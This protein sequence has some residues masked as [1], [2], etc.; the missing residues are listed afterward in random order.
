MARKGKQVKHTYRIKHLDKWKLLMADA[1]P[2]PEP[3][4]N[5]AKSSTNTNQLWRWDTFEDV[6]VNFVK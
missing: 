3:V 5:V 4:K 2:E 1:T 6:E